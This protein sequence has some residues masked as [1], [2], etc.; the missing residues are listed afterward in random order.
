MVAQEGK[1]GAMSEIIMLIWAKDTTIWDYDHKF[2]S[3]MYALERDCLPVSLSAC[4][5]CCPP[6]LTA[7]VIRPI[8][9]A[10]Q[11]KR[12]HERTLI[13]DVSPTQ[14]LTVLAEYGIL[15]DMLPTFMGGTIELNQSE[16]IANRESE[17]A[18][19]RSADAQNSC[20]GESRDALSPLSLLSA[21]DNEDMGNSDRK[22][23][24]LDK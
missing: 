2:D 9:F 18:R 16:Y 4:H 8:C 24:D 10:L 17:E 14:I 3:G 1:N 19:K 6:F 15:K 22:D 5:V 21:N 13:H 7:F 20:K 12:A 23:A 11:D